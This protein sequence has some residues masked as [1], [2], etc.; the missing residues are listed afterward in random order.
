MGE[1]GRMTPIAVR[2][3]WANSESIVSSRVPELV[4]AVPLFEKWSVGDG[5]PQW[6]HPVTGL[7]HLVSPIIEVAERA[8]MG[9]V[10]PMVRAREE[11][12]RADN[13]V[14]GLIHVLTDLPEP[15]VVSAVAGVCR[16]MHL[17]LAGEAVTLQ[18]QEPAVARRG[19]V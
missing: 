2:C 12:A 17:I 3:R 16:L 11:Q 19:K 5:R 6:V 8:R 14:S 13:L 1:D 7:G 4:A 15:G 9:E 10:D 18:Q